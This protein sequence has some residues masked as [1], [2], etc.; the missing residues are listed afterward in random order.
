MKT[1]IKPHD[2]RVSAGT[3]VD[4]EKWPT[5]TRPVYDSKKEYHQLLR[6]QVK[7]LAELQRLHYAA[8]RYSVLLIFQAM[9]TAGKDGA[10]GT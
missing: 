2:F 3:K 6:S 5:L 4:L 10:I 1:K 9:D 7:E 8:N